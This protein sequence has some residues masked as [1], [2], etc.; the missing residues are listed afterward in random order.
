MKKVIIFVVI[1]FISCSENVN[2]PILNDDETFSFNYTISGGVGGTNDQL[3][4]LESGDVI[5]LGQNYDFSTI[6]DG[7][8][9]NAL[10]VNLIINSFFSMDTAY[11]PDQRIADDILFKVSYNSDS[12]SKTV[13]ANGSCSNSKWPKG[14]KNIIDYLTDYITKLKS[15]I[16]SGEVIVISKMILEEWPFS[17]KIMLSDYL[18]KNVDADEEIFNHLKEQYKQNKQVVFFEGEWIYRLNGSGGYALNFN[19]LNSFYISIHDRN[20]PIEWPFGIKL[21]DNTENG[22]NLY[23][24]DYY[25][26]KEK[27][28]EVHYPRY[29]ISGSFESG[30]S[31]FEISLING[32]NL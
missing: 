12:K 24:E 25:W 20:K 9:T 18:S 16:N 19:E 14:L 1:L 8:E 11:L 4:I 23:G 30:E 17:D 15:K 7:N 26:L 32:N 22:I 29:F 21:E 13:I 6:A 2:N 3:T 28:K 10:L 5:Y 27:L 31:V